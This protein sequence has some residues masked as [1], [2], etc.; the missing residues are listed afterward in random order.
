MS[1]YVARQVQPWF[2]TLLAF[3]TCAMIGAFAWLGWRALIYLLMG[4]LSV[5][6]L[7]GLPAL[8]VALSPLL[9]LPFAVRRPKFS[10]E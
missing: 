9:A 5:K 2:W 7:I 3:W 4:F 6:P 1:S 10:P 8:L